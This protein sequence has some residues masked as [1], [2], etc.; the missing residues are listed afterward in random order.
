[1]PV[2]DT[3]ATTPQAAAAGAASRSER[4]W[5][6]SSMSATSSRETVPWPSNSSV[7]RP[8]SSVW[9]WTFKVRWSPTTRTESPIASSRSI[10]GTRVE[11]LARD[12]EVRAVAERGRRVLRV[13]DPGGRVVVELRRLRAA[14]GRDDAGEDHGEAEAAG[15]DHAR[16]AQ[17]GQQVRPAAD[18]GLPGVERALE[19]LGDQRVLAVG[20]DLLREPRLLHVGQ[21]GGDAVGH[22]ADDGEDRAL[23]RLADGVVGAVGRA[24]HGGADQHGVDQLARPRGQLLG[25]AADQLGEDDA[26]V[27]AGAEQRGPG[28]AVDDLVAADVVQRDAGE[29]VELVEHGAQRQRHVVPRVA[30]GDREHVEVVDLLAACLE[31]GQRA[32]DHGTEAEEA[33]I[34]HAAVPVGLGDLARL[35]AAGADVDALR[36]TG[37]RDAH[38]L[39]I[40]VEPAL[41]RDHGVRAALAEGR[42]LAAGVTDT[43]HCGREA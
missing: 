39:Q 14:Q 17:D 33:G 10:H 35:E 41:G 34:G 26:G 6:C 38:L 22:L 30:V 15:V 2:P 25:R 20:L 5:T 24:G 18:G 4:C 9:T 8:G 16:L 43:G 29:A 42:A 3:T 37:H 7:A 19:H 12:R 13:R 28:D 23:G 1:M 31:L 27:A 32:L 21:L 11:R 40:R 36:G